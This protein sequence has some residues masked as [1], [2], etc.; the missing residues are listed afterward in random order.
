MTEPLTPPTLETKRLRLRAFVHSDALE[1]ERLIAPREVT[2]GTLSFPH[3]V[4]EGWGSERIRIMLERASSGEHVE[5]AI[6]LLETGELIGGTG[7]SITARHKRGHL[8]Y[9]LGVDHWGKG[10][11]TEVASAVLRYGFDVLGLHRIEAGHYPRNPA[12]GRVLLKIGM[13][14]EGVMRGDL[15]KGDVFEDTVMYAI[16]ESD[17]Q[18]RTLEAP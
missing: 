17:P 12:S 8:G 7:L 5:F 15:L 11:A 2:D 6:T 16:L 1:F 4:P 18:S 14:L 10:Y 9:W 3:P 13:Q